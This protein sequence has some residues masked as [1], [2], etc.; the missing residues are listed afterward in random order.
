MDDLLTT[1]EFEDIAAAV[2][3]GGDVS[4]DDARSDDFLSWLLVH[5]DSIDPKLDDYSID[6]DGFDHTGEVAVT[7]GAGAVPAGAPGGGFDPSVANHCDGFTA[8]SAA[9]N[10]TQ[11]AAARSTSVPSSTERGA[12]AWPQGNPGAATTTNT[13]TDNPGQAGTQ[14]NGRAAAG[15]GVGTIAGGTGISAAAALL[16]T[17]SLAVV[18]GIPS[19]PV[20]AMQMGARMALTGN[21]NL[22]PFGLAAGAEGN[23]GGTEGGNTA[24]AAAAATAAQARPQLVDPSLGST[25]TAA[26]AGV[27]EATANNSVHPP[28]ATTAATAAAAG[29]TP[30]PVSRPGVLPAWTGL[31]HP[32]VWLKTEERGDRNASLS[33][34]YPN[35]AG[36]FAGGGA[37]WPGAG[38][39]GP[40]GSGGATAWSGGSAGKKRPRTSAAAPDTE[41]AAGGGGGS[42]RGARDAFKD[43]RKRKKMSLGE[44]EERV[45]QVSEDNERLKLHL[46][47]VNDKLVLM[48]SKKKLMEAEIA[49][50]LEA[51]RTFPSTLNQESLDEA[52]SRFKDLYADYGKQ[53]KQEVRRSWLTASKRALHKCLECASFQHCSQTRDISVLARFICQQPLLT[54]KSKMMFSVYLF[55]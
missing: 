24:S 52:L 15:V 13:A 37:G 27:T 7:G 51:Q 39:Q 34:A 46:S 28:A 53:R 29:G 45:K 54:S 32:P 26:G 49:A 18:G 50:K 2:G 38:G 10:P 11:S 41:G 21:L 25:S 19:D 30:D 5:A 8:Q 55:L 48:A 44:L 33:P 35:P 43:G 22:I 12:K 9:T 47:N 3:E 42:G 4:D 36:S 16:Q 17:P 6:T 20:L 23:A 40:G 1:D 31:P 14:G